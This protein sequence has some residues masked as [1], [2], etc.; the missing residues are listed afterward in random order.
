MGWTP[1]WARGYVPTAAEWAACFSVKPD[2]SDLAGKADAATVSAAGAQA[3]TMAAQVGAL[4]LGAGQQTVAANA[5][6]A[7][8]TALETGAAA[9][10]TSVGA[11]V[12]TQTSNTARITA[13][14]T[15]VVAPVVPNPVTAVHSTAA[16]TT[17][18]ALAWTAPAAGAAPTDY[19]VEWS[20]SG[21]NVW[22][23]AGAGLVG[24]TG[25]TKTVTGLTASTSLVTKSYLFRVTSINA[26]GPCA[27]SV[28]IPAAVATAIV[29][30]A[31]P[32][33]T[34]VLVGSAA[35]IT[36]ANGNTW[37]ISSGGVVLVN[38]S[39]DNTTNSVAEI[40]YVSGKV[41][42]ENSFGWWYSKTL[43]SDG[44]S[45]GTQTS[46]L[47]AATGQ[48]PQEAIN[49]G[50]T[51]MV[52]GTDSFVAGNVTNDISGAN[53]TAILYNADG[54]GVGMPSNGWSIANGIL[55]ITAGTDHGQGLQTCN[56]AGANFTGPIS[57]GPVSTNG[58]QTNAGHGVLHRYCCVE[59]MI[60]FNW[61][62]GPSAAFW[63]WSY[64]NGGAPN[65][66]E[67]DF[68]E[69]G[70]DGNAYSFW[71]GHGAAGDD[72]PNVNLLASL[73]G[74]LSAWSV[75]NQRLNKSNSPPQFNRISFVW[76]PGKVE[77]WYNGYLIQ[78]FTLDTAIPWS[79]G[80]IASGT[81]EVANTIDHLAQ[82]AL[83][84]IFG[85][86]NEP[87]DIAMFR[88]WQ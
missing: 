14:E 60:R 37:G 45:A 56:G 54:S 17:T 20:L 52:W 61:Q 34:V 59:A 85:T 87:I 77:W 15:K 19:L 51:N 13:L 36:D 47:P 23:S 84:F 35:L 4:Q 41:W 44:W 58:R 63:A 69:V 38:G 6:L 30:G 9:A 66:W 26:A 2:A 88:V 67:P 57:V 43:P 24:G 39:P 64:Q 81:P 71:H 1:N 21:S 82:M 72:G 62:A 76:T 7:R 3:Q 46:P 78:N 10:V 74:S 50:F 75:P 80:G 70:A 12:A 79:G 22:S 32:D 86:Y 8:L 55:T 53:T 49:A 25:V 68:L 5:V 65:T 27:T 11:V 48:P 28:L 31:S 29:A 83:A 16:T 42:Q 73:N 33:L 18:I 40:A